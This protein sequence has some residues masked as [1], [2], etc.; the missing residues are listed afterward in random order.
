VNSGS[1]GA[2]VQAP[3]VALGPGPCDGAGDEIATSVNVR[4]KVISGFRSR[5]VSCLESIAGADHPV[6]LVWILFDDDEQMP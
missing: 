4:L 2:C 5:D 3:L 6:D 1:E